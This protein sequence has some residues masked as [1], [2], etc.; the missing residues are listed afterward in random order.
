MTR[1]RRE[2]HGP[3]FEGAVLGDGEESPPRLPADRRDLCRFHF[4]SLRQRLID[5]ALREF[6]ARDLLEARDVLDLRGVRDLSAER[7]LLDHRDAFARAECVDRCRESRRSSADDDNICHN[8]ESSP[9]K[10]L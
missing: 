4:R 7:V 9:V 10:S 8:F 6:D 3:A 5:E 2:D 1:A